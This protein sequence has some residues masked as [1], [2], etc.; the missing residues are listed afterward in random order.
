MSLRGGGDDGDDIK[1]DTK[2]TKHKKVDSNWT[3]QVKNKKNILFDDKWS[4]EG[5]KI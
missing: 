5:K 4:E 2:N 3:R 1:F